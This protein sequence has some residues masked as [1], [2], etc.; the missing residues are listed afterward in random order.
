M[1]PTQ[2]ATWRSELR[3]SQ[4]AAADAL[5]MAKTNYQALERGISWSTGKPVKIDRR[6]ALACAAIRAGIVPEGESQA[7]TT[8]TSTEPAPSTAEQ[9]A[10]GLPATAPG[11]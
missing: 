5:G 3:L 9:S 7:H 2:L 6:T 8:Q 11:Q 1:T 4:Q 10:D